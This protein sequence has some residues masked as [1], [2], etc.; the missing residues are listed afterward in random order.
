MAEIGPEGYKFLVKYLGLSFVSNKKKFET[1]KKPILKKLEKLSEGSSDRIILEQM[2]RDIES[3]VSDAKNY[4]PDG[5]LEKLV[6]GIEACLTPSKDGGSKNDMVTSLLP[7]VVQNGLKEGEA[8]EIVAAAI[9]R[10]HEACVEP[11][12]SIALLRSRLKVERP[13]LMIEKPLEFSTRLKEIRERAVGV[14]S[15]DFRATAQLHA[16]LLRSKDEQAPALLKLMRNGIDGLMRGLRIELRDLDTEIKSVTGDPDKLGVMLDKIAADNAVIERRNEWQD[17]RSKAESAILQ[18]EWWDAPEAKGL[19]QSLGG[20]TKPDGD[21]GRD[22]IAIK[23]ADDLRERAERQML[24]TRNAFTKERDKVLSELADIKEKIRQVNLDYSMGTIG[25]GGIGDSGD[26]K[27]DKELLDSYDRD[28]EIILAIV[29]DGFNV[30]ALTSAREMIKELVSRID[31]RSVA[32]S[33]GDMSKL[34]RLIDTCT[35]VIENARVQKYMPDT[36]KEQ[37]AAFE[38]V[39]TSTVGLSVDQQISKFQAIHDTLIDVRDEADLRREAVKKFDKLS[40]DITKMLDKIAEALSKTG[41][42]GSVDTKDK[43]FKHYHGPLAQKLEAATETAQTE[44]A[45]EVEKAVIEAGKIKETAT[46]IILALKTDKAKRTGPQTNM[47]DAATKGQVDGVADLKQ[48]KADEKTFKDAVREFKDYAD[49]CAF[50]AEGRPEVVN[51][52]KG[53]RTMSENAT[54]I[55]EATHDLKRALGIL[56]SARSSVKRTLNKLKV[57]P[58]DLARVADEWVAACG[59]LEKRIEGLAKKA[60][61]A[62]KDLPDTSD[63]KIAAGQVDKKLKD[64]IVPLKSVPDFIA[65]QKIYSQPIPQ[66]TDL[67][68]ARELTLRQV[69]LLNELIANHPLIRAAQANPFGVKDV[70]S[71][72]VARLRSIE[73]KA[74]VTV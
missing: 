3:R 9:G 22:A 33:T 64:A 11:S 42:L 46:E 43:D 52:I 26:L 6:R 30:L 62:V 1:Y 50:E 65:A 54:E 34:T 37:K 16:S 53:Y 38:K 15:V 69:R 59:N 72:L 25:V 66:A 19:R 10:V 32:Q 20:L 35:S 68:T 18:L 70:V 23:A 2:L 17:A 5:D 73:L 39:Q 58:S 40:A 57:R 55:F 61:D 14:L 21:P 7:P 41:A 47:I 8:A 67:K 31:Q 36:L 48:R 12:K 44:T 51:E 29:G 13:D 63:L 4:D 74:L 45:A 56:D 49:E 27:I 71:P 60:A 28:V 24:T